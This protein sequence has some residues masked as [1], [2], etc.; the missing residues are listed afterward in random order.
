MVIENTTVANNGRF[1][2]SADGT[3]NSWTISDSDISD[4]AVKLSGWQNFRS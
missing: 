3:T 4:N 2:I 1:G